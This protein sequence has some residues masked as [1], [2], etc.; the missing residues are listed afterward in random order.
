MVTGQWYHIAVVRSS[1]VTRLYVN[2][3][4]NATTYTDTND[5]GVSSQFTIGGAG[6]SLGAA[7][8]FTN[9]HISDVRVT[10][11]A[12]Y[13]SAFTPPTSP[14]SLINNTTMLLSFTNA[15]IIDQTSSMNISTFSGA[16]LSTSQEQFGTSSILLNGT[17]DYIS[18]V[19]QSPGFGKGDFTIECWIF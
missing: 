11:S 8:T 3:V 12:V 17:T 14:L 5:Y 4:A 16:K 1:G 19:G 10:K 18:Q 15:K 7:G 6:D 9:G 2:G 13:S